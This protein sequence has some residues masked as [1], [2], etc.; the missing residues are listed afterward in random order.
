MQVVLLQFS[1]ILFLVGKQRVYSVVLM[2]TSRGKG[3]L[4]GVDNA[5]LQ[6]CVP[7]QKVWVI[8]Y[9]DWRS[10]SRGDSAFMIEQNNIYV[11]VL[12]FKKLCFGA[13]MFKLFKRLQKI[14]H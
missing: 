13:I 7:F 14:Q 12:T 10:M 9:L 1:F 3:N 2:S 11:Y 8:L 4:F 5:T 6:Q